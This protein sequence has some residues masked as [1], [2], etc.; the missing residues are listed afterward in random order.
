MFLD[1]TGSDT[2][3]TRRYGRAAPGRRV[4][5]GVPHGHWERLTVVG[6]LRWDGTT[7]AM[8]LDGALDTEGLLAYAE[9]VLVPTLKRGDVVVL[10]NL[11]SHHDAQFRALIEAQGARLVHLPPYSP[12]FNPIEKLWS[13]VK[14]HLRKTKARTPEALL[15]AWKEALAA[16]TADD[17]HGWFGECGYS[18]VAP[19]VSSPTGTFNP[20]PV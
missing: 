17:A 18:T 7:T 6:S 13:K 19:Q 5:E 16:V 9:H 12:D 15:A 1:E 11:A 8:A 2:A 3:M 14:E 4:V 20:E 10:D